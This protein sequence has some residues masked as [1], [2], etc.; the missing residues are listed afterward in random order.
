MDTVS[1]AV[2]ATAWPRVW[3]ATILATQDLLTSMVLAM[4]SSDRPSA[5]RPCTRATSS[6]LSTAR[7][8]ASPIRCP[9][10]L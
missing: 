4:A 9:R 2:R 7:G 10:S 8:W 1:T 6:S 5:R 3:P